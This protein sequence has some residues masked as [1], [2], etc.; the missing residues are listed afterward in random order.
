M[1]NEHLDVAD[2]GQDDV[3][4]PKIRKVKRA[5]RGSDSPEPTE[6]EAKPKVAQYLQGLGKPKLRTTRLNE[7]ILLAEYPHAIAGTLHFLP[8]E[9]KQAVEIECQARKDE[10][11]DV[12]TKAWTGGGDQCG[13]RREVRTSD[14]FQVQT[15]EVCTLKR[16]RAKAKARRK[17]ANDED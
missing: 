7:E 15:C 13:R 8:E 3:S 16:R 4:E 12:P 11:W 1:D 5:L 17:A 6:A 14:L 10:T 2:E 9:R